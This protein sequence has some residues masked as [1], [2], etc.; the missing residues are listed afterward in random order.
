MLRATCMILKLPSILAADSFGSGYWRCSYYWRRLLV[1]LLLGL[2]V[3]RRLLPQL[4]LQQLLLLLLLLVLLRL[5]LQAD[6]GVNYS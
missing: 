4:E 5:L 6:A 2:L 3:L 1:Q